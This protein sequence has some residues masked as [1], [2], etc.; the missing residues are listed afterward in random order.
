VF[1]S[2]RRYLYGPVS[3]PPNPTFSRNSDLRATGYGVM[4][5]GLNAVQGP[6]PVSL[7]MS[8]G[9]EVRGVL[10]GLE[11]GIAYALPAPTPVDITQSG[12]ALVTQLS[13]ASLFNMNNNP[14]N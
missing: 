1:K 8:P 6:V 2:I 5:M 13:L 14:T 3:S 10:R 7:T 12:Q 11:G 9:Q 4:N